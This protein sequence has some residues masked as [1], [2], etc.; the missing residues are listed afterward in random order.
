MRAICLI[1]F[2]TIIISQLQAKDIFVAPTGDDITGTGAIESPYKTIQKA[3]KVAV[4]GDVVQVRSGIYR[5]TVIPTKS[6]TAGSPITYQPYNN[7]TVTISGAEIVSAWTLSSGN[8]YTAAL[9]AKFM[10]ESHNQSDQ[11]FV[12]GV[13][14]NLARWPNNTNPDPTYPTKATLSAPSTS[15]TKTGNLT[16]V[17]FKSTETPPA[18]AAGAEIYVQPNYNAWSWTLTGKVTSVS[19]STITMTS[20]NDA[21]VEGNNKIYAKGSKY[22]LFNQLS[23]LDAPGEW[24]HDKTNN[25]LYLWCP[26]GSDPS[27]K[28]VEAKKREYAFNLSNKSYITIKGFNLFSCS[29]T[30]DSEA[31][32]NNKGFDASGNTVYPWRIVGFIAPSKNCIVDGITAKYLSHFT[33]VSGHFYLQWGQSSGIVM[34][35]TDQIIK[36]SIIQYSAG[37]GITLAGQRCK[38]LNNYVSD[39]DYISNDCSGIN[40][41]G[42]NA[43]TQDHEIAWNTIT[44]T[45]RSGITPRAMLNTSKTSQLARVHHNE[46]SYF[47]LQDWDGGGIYTAGMNG[48]FARIDHNVIHEASGFLCG[49]VYIDWCKN[50]IIDHNVVYNVE[51]GIHLQHNIDGTTTGLSNMICYN[52]TVVVKN[53]SNSGY[54]PFGFASS[55]P[56]NTQLG[57][58]CKNNVNVYRNGTSSV[59]T[60]GY[61]PFSNAFD[62]ATKSNN[63][64]H[65]ADPKFVDFVGGD[66]TLL[67]GSPAIDAGVPMEEVSLDGNTIPPYND[68]AIGSVD[69]G[70]YEFGT[71]N[72]K[73]GYTDSQVPSAP[74]GL[75]ATDLTSSG[76]T[77]NWTAS[78]DNIGVSV[79]EAWQG[80]TLLGSTSGKNTSMILTSL[81][82]GT[83]Y[84]VVLKAKDAAGNSSESRESLSVT[85]IFPTSIQDLDKDNVRIFGNDRVIV[86]DLSKLVENSRVIIYDMHGSVI[87]IQQS[88]GNEVLRIPFPDTGIYLVRVE[89]GRQIFIQKVIIL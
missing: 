13:M 41:G 10:D 22:Y 76:F 30:T 84:Q 11:V 50:F 79:Y 67:A 16:T 33:D 83:N 3:A 29:I 78:A 44:R 47:M 37:N 20:F 39:V 58:I 57:S 32:G 26:D 80:E 2:L 7:E 34:S 5:E 51:W 46:I 73:V 52:N 77:L 31:G 74:S 27:K 62:N 82:S 64:N 61:L 6:G 86:V 85:T 15:K 69:I 87:K 12:D 43:V 65:P 49:G 19:G 71:S 40:T 75:S 8:I 53:T 25:L 63:L 54:G 9:A 88:K 89:N 14:M 72:W 23:L 1:F 4:A 45:G 18:N 17:V 68:E 28:V 66:L 48:G 21:G 60:S 36:N 81:T 42:S 59:K 24:F 35:G 70:A 56:Q 55:A 38:A